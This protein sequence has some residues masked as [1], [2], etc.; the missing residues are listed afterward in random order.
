MLKHI[1][2]YRLYIRLVITQA[3]AICNVN[4]SCSINVQSFLPKIPNI[5]THTP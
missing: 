4:S 3:F 2:V 5:N 1:I